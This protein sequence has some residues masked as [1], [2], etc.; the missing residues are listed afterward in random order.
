MQLVWFLV[1]LIL[2][3][4]IYYHCGNHPSNKPRIY[5][6]CIDNPEEFK[7]VAENN[8]YLH[9]YTCDCIDRNHIITLSPQL[10]VYCETRRNEYSSSNDT[11]KHN[12]LFFVWIRTEY[13]KRT[14]KLYNLKCLDISLDRETFAS[15]IS[16]GTF[17]WIKGK[18]RNT[19][20][21]IVE[22]ELLIT[23]YVLKPVFAPSSFK[24]KHPSSTFYIIDEKPTNTRC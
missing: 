2:M 8:Y 12:V 15:F 24:N 1:P 10:K 14:L 21:N 13:H 9:I 6:Q 23:N 22:I 19:I 7:K 11:Y 20:K 4:Y 18:D 5:N 16:V 3:E 17:I